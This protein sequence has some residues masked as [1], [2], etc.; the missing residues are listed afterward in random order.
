MP[1]GSL[2]AKLIA[3][4]ENRGIL[5]QAPLERRP[6]MKRSNSSWVVLWW[7]V[8]GMAGGQEPNSA[9]PLARRE[10]TVEGGQR[11]GLVAA[12]AGAKTSPSPVVFA[13]HGHGGTMR[14]AAR[15]MPYHVLWPEAIVVYPQGLNTPGR[16]TDPEGRRPGWQHAAGEQNDRDLKFFDAMLASLKADYKVDER[17]IYSTGHSNGGGFTYLLWATRGDKLAAVAP[18]ASAALR[19]LGDLKPKPVLHV[20]GEQDPLVKFEWQRLT[21]ERLKQINGCE[22]EG[23][24]WAKSCTQYPSKN[25]TPVVTLIHPGDHKFLAEAPPLIVRFFKELVNQEQ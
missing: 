15:M 10:W 20:A 17:R 19:R 25:G 16:L 3:V 12:P 2:V 1:R 7:L 13:F 8:V 24:S 6:A 4:A 9:N 21:I 23:A 18:S 14:N 11:E 5:K 22:K